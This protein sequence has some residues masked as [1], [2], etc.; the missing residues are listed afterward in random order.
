MSV[1]YPTSLTYNNHVNITGLAPYTTY[2]YLPQ[3]SNVTTLYSFT[4]ARAA[5]D[6]TPFTVGIVVDMG[7]FG[8]PGL[9][10]DAPEAT[11]PLA[12]NEQ[13]TIAALISM[14]DSYEFMVHAG[15]MAYADYW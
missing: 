1:T 2:Y 9:S 4:T 15:D 11:H 6:E 13:T 12:L 5:G 3:D 7:T 10:S 14:K 8:Y